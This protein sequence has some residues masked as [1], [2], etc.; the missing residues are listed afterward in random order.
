MCIPPTNYHL[1]AAKQ[2]P[3]QKTYLL[4]KTNIAGDDG[5][6]YSH[7]SGIGDGLSVG[8]GH[9]ADIGDGGTGEKGEPTQQVVLVAAVVQRG[10]VRGREREIRLH[11]NTP[12]PE[13]QRE[14]VSYRH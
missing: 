9:E 1:L 2:E 6:H 12:T 14:F 4:T 13:R 8:V 3:Y 7:A 11:R 5:E 10:A